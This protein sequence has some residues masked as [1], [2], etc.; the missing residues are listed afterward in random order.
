MVAGLGGAALRAVAL[1]R[2]NRNIAAAL[3]AKSNNAG[4]RVLDALSG[5]P[6][7]LCRPRAL[8]SVI[9]TCSAT[10]EASQINPGAAAIDGLFG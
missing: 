2:H 8:P 10:Q 1:C 4:R 5:C 3:Y 7:L 6:L 9:V